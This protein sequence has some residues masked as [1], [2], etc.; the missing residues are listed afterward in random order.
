MRIMI[1]TGALILLLAAAIF[2]YLRQP[3]FG[4]MPSG[5]RLARIERSPHYKNGRFHNLVE[6]PTLSEGYS[7]SREVYNTFFTEH[8][9]RSPIDSLPSVRTDLSKLPADT[10]VAVWFG[11]SSVFIQVDGK[12]ILVDP[13]FSG[14]ASPLPGSVEAYKGSNIY[15]AADMPPIDYLLISHDHYDHL[16]YETVVALKDKV[17]HVVCGL[18]VAEHF[19]HWG[20]APEQIIEKDW[21]EAIAVDSGFT[22]YTESS[23]HE[24]GRGFVRDK[25]L[26]M[27]Y[28][29]Q[30][31][32]LRIYVSG[33]GG[34]DGRFAETE[35]KF[36]PVD[37]AIMDDGQ[38]DK[39]WQSVHLLPE[40][41]RQE[42]LDLK[43]RHLLPVHHSKFTLAK[44]AW[45][46]PLIRTRELSVSQPYRMATPMIGE[47]VYLD[48]PSQPF[49]EWWKGVK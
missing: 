12:R 16:D 5:E 24:S 46:E 6:K 2:T 48:N 20:Y 42:T 30:A 40:E 17:K 3:Q 36:G 49:K 44:H 8:P 47:V 23:H 25:T 10:N 41:V 32:G 45:D 27:S 13:S 4:K 33:D 11:H 34:Y 22:I 1:I 19:E 43:A 31:P 39:A 15:S 29:I 35:R 7:T 26:W 9:S 37:W 38:Y 14:R 21:Y 18:G 28:L